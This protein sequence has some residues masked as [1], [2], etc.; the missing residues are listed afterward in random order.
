MLLA[1]EFLS[2]A[3]FVVKALLPKIGIL[4]RRILAL[5]KADEEN[6][7]VQINAG[8]ICMA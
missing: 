8:R 4:L 6:L 1:H 5:G 7:Q 3:N 2:F